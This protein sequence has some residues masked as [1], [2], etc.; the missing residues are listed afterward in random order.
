MHFLREWQA[1]NN[2]FVSTIQSI[3][4]NKR[5]LDKYINNEF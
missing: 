1:S 4:K 3:F 5:N 2:I